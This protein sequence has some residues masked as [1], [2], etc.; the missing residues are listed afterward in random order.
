[1]NVKPRTVIKVFLATVIG[2]PAIFPVMP[3]ALGQVAPGYRELFRPPYRTDELTPADLPNLGRLVTLE[4][5]S[6]YVHVRAEMRNSPESYRLLAE[7]ITL[8]NAAD[9][10]TAA[11]SYYP[12]ETQGIEAGRLTFPQLEAA[13]Y[14]V[15]VTQGSLPHIGPRTAENLAD[16]S[17]VMAVIGPLLELAPPQPL[18]RVD[19]R[20]FDPGAISNQARELASAIVPLKNQ[21]QAEMGRG[22]ELEPL[23]REIDLL[24]KLLLGFERISRSGVNERDLV[25]SF[26]PIQRL[27][28]RIRR[29]PRRV[30][31]TD[32]ALSLWRTIDQQMSDLETRFLI[33]R[34][35]VPRLAQGQAGSV[36][37]AVVAPA[38]RAIRDLDTLVERI[39]AENP[40]IPQF[41]RLQTDARNLTTRLL[42]VRQY[43]IGQAP[44]EQVN[45]ALV[46]LGVSWHQ[47]EIRL[48]H[49]GLGKSDPLPT[50]RK[51]VSEVIARAR[52]DPQ[53]ALMLTPLRFSSHG[54]LTRGAS[55][56]PEGRR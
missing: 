31:L 9:D 16:M 51:D 46:D 40:R 28:Q 13:F 17:R 24:E 43:L 55:A 4:A 49:P 3:A 23:D 53:A 48:T 25:A 26:R 45:Q 34:E 19:P 56:N 20:V 8:W 41:D 54:L 2:V 36:D 22:V 42:L 44:R 37:L 18:A 50:L 47:L 10:F 29:E 12:L 38:E 39:A 27:A 21:V 35:I 30:L 5:I 33:P 7:I 6:M 32:A 1:M 15:K 52:A 14:Q 11:I